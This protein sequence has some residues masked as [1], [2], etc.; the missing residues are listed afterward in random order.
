VTAGLTRL[1]VE[2]KFEPGIYRIKA[3]A[4]RPPIS[5][6]TRE[7][8]RASAKERERKKAEQRALAKSDA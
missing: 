5:E 4:A 3:L 7:K 2:I 8:L 6:A 1:P